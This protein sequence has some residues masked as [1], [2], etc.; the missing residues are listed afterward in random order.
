MFMSSASWETGIDAGRYPPALAA[1]QALGNPKSVLAGT[2]A[3]PSFPE[4]PN[5]LQ[6]SA[7]D[8]RSIRSQSMTVAPAIPVPAA[9]TTLNVTSFVSGSRSWAPWAA[10]S[11]EACGVPNASGAP[12]SWPVRD[13]ATGPFASLDGT[14]RTRTATPVRRRRAIADFGAFRKSSTPLVPWI[15]TRILDAPAHSHGRASQPS[16]PSRHRSTA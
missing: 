1:T 15:G 5:G 14:S 10:V 11:L 9:S 6:T 3:M 7:R 13:V 2:L 4:S 12:A 16:S 8:T